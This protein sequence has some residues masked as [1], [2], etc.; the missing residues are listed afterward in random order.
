MVSP[1]MLTE[2]LLAATGVLLIAGV[3][4]GLYVIV[5]AVVLAMVG[6]VTSAWLFLT[7]LTG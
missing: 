2:T 3:D 4:D 7:K 6:G 1:N 5:P